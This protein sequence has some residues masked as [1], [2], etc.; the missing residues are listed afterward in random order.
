M[1]Q[2]CVKDLVLPPQLWHS[3]TVA[4]VRSLVWELP[5]AVGTA[6]KERKI[7]RKKKGKKKRKER[8]TKKETA[9]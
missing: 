5:H 3:L 1:A 6:K 7:E 4:W 8:G 9:V 2:S